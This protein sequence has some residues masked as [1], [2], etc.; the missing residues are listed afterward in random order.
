MN[1][2]EF[3]E[4]G[5]RAYA[6]Q[7]LKN[8]PGWEVLAREVEAR[9]GAKNRWLLNGNAKTLED[10]RGEAGWVNGA[11]DVLALADSLAE[12]I[13][14]ERKRRDEAAAQAKGEAA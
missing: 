3:R 10:Y 5:E 11:R 1:D 2:T 8:H 12:Q 7:T 14:R 9:A 6:L 4:L 13:E